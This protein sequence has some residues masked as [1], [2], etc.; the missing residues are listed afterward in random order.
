MAQGADPLHGVGCEQCVLRHCHRDV[1]GRRVELGWAHPDPS[2]LGHDGEQARAAILA[3]RPTSLDEILDIGEHGGQGPIARRRGSAFRPQ[4]RDG[5]RPV[6]AARTADDK[7]IGIQL[8]LHL[9]AL[10]HSLRQYAKVCESVLVNRSASPVRWAMCA[11]ILYMLTLPLAQVR[12][13]LSEVVDTVESTAE[14]VVITRNGVPAA[15]V[16][17]VDDLAAMEETLG[18]LDG[19]DAVRRAQEADEAVDAGD[20]TERDEIEA[21]IAART[22]RSA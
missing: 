5:D 1:R 17:S 20:V 7:S 13:R 4:I 16:I 6:K 21:L 9:S 11:R 2:Q 12:A 14:R 10:R 19:P 18:W 15:V 3:E 8:D 22:R